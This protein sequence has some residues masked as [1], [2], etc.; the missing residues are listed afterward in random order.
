MSDKRTQMPECAKFVDEMRNIFGR[1][2]GGYAAENGIEVTWGNWVPRPFV[3][4]V[5]PVL[6]TKK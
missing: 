1:E 5:I 4:V 2:V 3:A 6:G